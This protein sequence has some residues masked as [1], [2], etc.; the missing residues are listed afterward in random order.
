LGQVINAIPD[1]A[2]TAQ[3][4]ADATLRA[5]RSSTTTGM[6]DTGANLIVSQ[7]TA[8]VKA[9]KSVKPYPSNEGKSLGELE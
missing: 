4:N 3:Q 5:F 1:A 6:S 2:P 8:A 9:G 7:V